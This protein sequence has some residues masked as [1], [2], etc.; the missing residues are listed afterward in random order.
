M[1]FVG[2]FLTSRRSFFF[3]FSNDGGILAL[4]FSLSCCWILGTV[5]LKKI[6]HHSSDLNC[7]LHVT[8]M[9]KDDLSIFILLLLKNV[10]FHFSIYCC[11]LVL[12]FLFCFQWFIMIKRLE[13]VGGYISPHLP[14]DQTSVRKLS[15]SEDVLLW[16]NT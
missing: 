13:T 4:T 2:S 12:F 9:L 16:F 7:V 3:Y 6:T 8:C 5:T 10:F 1:T 14:I 15:Y 11:L